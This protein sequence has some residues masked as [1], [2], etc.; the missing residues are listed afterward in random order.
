MML[1]GLANAADMPGLSAAA[2]AD[3]ADCRLDRNGLVCARR[4][5]LA[6]GL[7]DGANAPP[8]FRRSD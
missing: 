5:R 2:G 6:L 8:G 3:C 7:I 4:S 1:T